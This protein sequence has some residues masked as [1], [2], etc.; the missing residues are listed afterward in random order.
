M[1]IFMPQAGGLADVMGL[2]YTLTFWKKRELA[3]SEAGQ[4]SRLLNS[5]S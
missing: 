2:R 4:L 1:W 5:R 3:G